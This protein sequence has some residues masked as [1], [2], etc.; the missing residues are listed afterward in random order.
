MALNLLV[1]S[2]T[3]THLWWSWSMMQ[4]TFISTQLF[5]FLQ[6]FLIASN[7]SEKQSNLPYFATMFVKPFV[8]KMIIGLLYL[9]NYI[10]YKHF[11]KL[12]VYKNTL[13]SPCI[14]WT[15]MK[16]SSKCLRI[17]VTTVQFTD[18]KWFSKTV[19]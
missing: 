10:Q 5:N 2:T 8:S 19:F 18:R 7:H 1:W 9:N 12:V 6:S 3:I 13:Q 14:T 16:T 11:L 17:L 4:S 15:G